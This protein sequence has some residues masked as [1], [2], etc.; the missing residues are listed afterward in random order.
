METILIYATENQQVLK[1]RKDLP[2]G[3]WGT[4]IFI[5]VVILILS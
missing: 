4:V 3:S 5:G 1:I 2:G